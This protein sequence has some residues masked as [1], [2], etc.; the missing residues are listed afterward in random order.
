MG[1]PELL[2]LTISELA[3]KI[4]SREVS[5]VEVMEAALAQADRLQSSLNSFITVVHDQAMA[6]AREEEADLARG[7]NKGPLQGIPIGIKDNLATKDIRTTLASKVLVD[8]V[9]GEDA[10]A[11]SLCVSKGAIVIGKENMEE[12][13]AGATSSNSYFGPVHNPW[14]LDHIPGGSSGGGGA[15]VAASVT[16]ASLGT[17][18]GGSVR[19]PGS[20]CGVVGLK[21]TFG[22]VS[23]RGILVTSFNGDH[24]GPLTRSVRDS[25]LML[26][27]IAGYDP[28]D[29]STVPVRVPDYS[30]ALGK[31]LR[32]TRVGIPTNYFFEEVD[33]EVEAAV[34]RAAAELKGLGAELREVSI[35]SMRYA[36]AIRVAS[37]ADSVVTHEPYIRSRRKDYGHDVLYRALAGQFVTARDYVKV[38]K[39][40]RLMKEEFARVLQEVDL[41]VTPTSRVPAIPIGATSLTVGGAEH[42]MARGAGTAIIAGNTFPINATG[43]PAITVPCGFTQSGLPIGL[44]LIGRP[45]EEELLFCA[46]HQYEA[47]APVRGKRPP[48]VDGPVEVAE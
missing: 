31:D 22:L 34:W 12:F 38:L 32:G 46:A 36:G 47:V 27:A 45:F 4:R 30:A 43:L 14:V 25:A 35:P 44:Q 21:Q 18:V 23:Q 11:V 2:K 41:L 7:V 6:R 1:T 10:H 13:A 48:L 37:M 16:F 5:P 33:E 28:M 19:L 9:P 3:P 8:N 40:Q 20:L 15:N 17:D 39:A 42:E 26:Q 29:P 24:V